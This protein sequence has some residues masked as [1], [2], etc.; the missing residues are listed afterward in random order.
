MLGAVVAP[1]LSGPQRASAADSVSDNFNRANGSLGAD[2]TNVADGRLA[3]SS[4]VIVGT[5]AALRRHPHRETYPNDQYSQIEVTLTQL[6]VGQSIG[7]AMRA[8]SPSDLYLGL[9][10]WNKTTR[11]SCCSAVGG[12]WTHLDAS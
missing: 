3:I 1:V 5:I 2:W 12:N 6:S 8:Q 9:Y 7:A 4:Q 10:F 11:N